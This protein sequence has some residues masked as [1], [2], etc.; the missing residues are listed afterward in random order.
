[1]NTIFTIGFT[2][3][4]AQNFFEIL[5][6]NQIEII[7][8]IRLN[9]TSQLSAFSKY[10]DIKFFLQKI[11]DI[12]YIHDINFSPNENTLKKYKKKI[13]DW[14]HYICE[15]NNTMF[16]R[17]IINYIKDN[18]TNIIDKRICLLCSEPTAINC[19][20]SLVA[21]YFVNCFDNLNII[22]L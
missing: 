4:T 5:S 13:I 20:R 1:M 11:C 14:Q 10:P 2:K 18:Y 9:N 21:K 22:H 17:N 8:D 6:H 19:H 3:K 16:E 12:E 15:F 7:L